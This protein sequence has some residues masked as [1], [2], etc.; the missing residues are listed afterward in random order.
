MSARHPD[1]IADVASHMAIMTAL[2]RLAPRQRMAI[3]L[4]YHADLP[5]KQIARAMQCRE[6]TVKS[7]LHTA[8]AH[9]RTL[10]LDD[11]STTEVTDERN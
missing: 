8:L 4:R 9:L 6:G 2:G 3:V 5:I 10:P 11:R 7:T 1:P